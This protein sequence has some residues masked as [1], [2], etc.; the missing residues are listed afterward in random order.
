MQGEVGVHGAMNGDPH[1]AATE[2][3]FTDVINRVWNALDVARREL[4]SQRNGDNIL[5][6]TRSTFR[7]RR[8]ARP[9]TGKGFWPSLAL[10]ISFQTC[11]VNKISFTL[12]IVLLRSV[13]ML[14]F[15]LT[16]T[17]YNARSRSVDTQAEFLTVFFYRVMVLCLNKVTVCG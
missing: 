7:R 17:T 3:G 16:F 9:I 12:Y 6:A 15:A 8:R 13:L 11:P 5:M 4:A 1:D 2:S 14:S 10:A